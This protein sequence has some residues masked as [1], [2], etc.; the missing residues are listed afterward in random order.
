MFIKFYFRIAYHI[1]VQEVSSSQNT[2][3]G[4]TWYYMVYNTLGGITWYYMVLH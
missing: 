3:G 2:M 4:V 1:G